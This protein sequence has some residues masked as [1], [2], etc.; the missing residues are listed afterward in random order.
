ELKFAGYDVIV[1]KGISNKPVYISIIN[2]QVKFND[3]ND[4][5]GMETKET[6]DTIKKKL[7]DKAV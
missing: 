1:V 7:N 3:A 5:W 2:G 4:I 6:I